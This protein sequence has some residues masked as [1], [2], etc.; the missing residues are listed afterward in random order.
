[1]QF[2]RQSPGHHKAFTLIEALL[3]MII[4]LLLLTFLL[5]TLQQIEVLNAAMNLTE[6]AVR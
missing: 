6:R 4:I 5:S 3:S 1:M 2:S